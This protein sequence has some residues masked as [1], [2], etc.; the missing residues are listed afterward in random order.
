MSNQSREDLENETQTAIFFRLHRSSYFGDRTLETE[1]IK[2]RVAKR[3]FLR[4][5]RGED[6]LLITAEDALASV[7]VIEAAYADL[8]RSHWVSV[9]GASKPTV[10]QGA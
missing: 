7:E 8:R 10:A 3:T 2:E 9:V 6:V 4:A 1:S 5:I